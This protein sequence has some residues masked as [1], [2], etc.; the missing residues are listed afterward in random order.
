[1]RF[2]FFILFTTIS[3]NCFSQNFSNLKQNKYAFDDTIFIDSS[4]I[5]PSSIKIFAE[6]EKINDS[7][8]NF[9]FENSYLYFKQNQNYDTIKIKYRSLNYNFRQVALNDS[10]IIVPKAIN[11]YDKNKRKKIDAGKDLKSGEIKSNGF[12]SRSV[13]V[14]NNQDAV[15]SSKM[16]LKLSGKLNDD[17]NV[18]ARA[19]DETMPIQPDGNTAKI[20][21]LNNI[22]LSAYN[23]N[24]KLKAGDFNIIKPKSYFLKYNKQVKG[25]EYVKKN[26]GINEFFTA[27]QLNFGAAISKG[28]Y[29]SQKISGIEGNQGPYRLLGNSGETY[30]V[31]LAGSERVY[32]DGKLLKRGENFDY[33][34]NYNTAEIVFTAKNPITKDSRIIVEFEYSERNYSRF[35]LYSNN[36][37]KTSNNEFYLN[38][39]SETDAKN[40]TIDRE[41]SSE[42]KEIMFNAGDSLNKALYLN[43]DS[44]SYSEDKILYEKID[45]LIDDEVFTIYKHS[46]NP[47]KAIYQVSFAYVGAGKGNYKIAENATNG[48]IYEFIEPQDSKKQGDYAPYLLLVTPKKHQI[49]DFGGKL[50]I[51]PKNKFFFDIALSNKDLNLF[52]P[53]NDNDN[54]ALALKFNYNFYL[55]G[56]D[57]TSDKR[58]IF[59][60][61]EFEGK[62][63]TPVETFRN[64][65]YKRDWNITSQFSS[66]THLFDIG[67]YDKSDKNIFSSSFLLLHHFKEFLGL[68]PQ[69]SGKRVAKSWKLDYNANLMH[70]SDYLNNTNFARSK[71]LFSKKIF[72]LKTGIDYQQETNIWQKIDTDTLLQNSFMFHSLAFFIENAD[73]SEFLFHS[74]YKRR[75]DFSPEIKSLK[76]VSYS[77]N[78]NFNL[79]IKKNKYSANFVLNYRQ[80][81][82][83]DTAAVNYQPENNLN[84]RAL[85]NFSILKDILS[86]STILEFSSGLEQKMQFIFVEVEPT[87]GV[88]TW[89]DYNNDNIKQIDEFEVAAFADEATFVKVPVQSNEYIKVYTKNFT[90]NLFFTPA[91][92]FY[93]TLFAHKLFSKF[94]DNLSVNFNHKSYNFNL[95]DF[96]DT[97]SFNY[98]FGLNNIL[99][100]N[101][102]KWMKINYLWQKNKTKLL[103]F[104]GSDNIIKNKKTLN[105]V[106]IFPANVKLSEKL[107]TKTNKVSSDYSALKNY[108]ILNNETITELSF[109]EKELTFGISYSYSDKRNLSG[110]EIL[111]S[112]KIATNLNLIFSKK[113]GITVNFN[114]IDNNFKGDASTSVAYT[115]LGGLKPGKNYTWDFIFKRKL[116]KILQASISYSG[117]YSKGNKII[118][119]GMISVMAFL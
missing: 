40:Q 110:D 38:F 52:S 58:F 8:W 96:S 98:N 92:F 114:F 67:F 79:D 10:S 86:F 113:S 65:E 102:F 46:K 71:F 35:T 4:Y 76:K 118:H 17:I 13:G 15:I 49:I 33:K 5:F 43:A 20:E 88:Y 25:I 82:I 115:M 84:T 80:L 16:N 11:Y 90:Q 107:S 105:T 7:L 36:N 73:T 116:G 26:T 60:G 81:F 54:K 18:E 109:S 14:G 99:N 112:N 39:Y 32:L 59:T 91:K 31:V 63:F 87:K 12:I 83:S 19:Y 103:H 3:L 47:Q 62:N 30:I 50:N 42:M 1:M 93:D 106:F 111:F 66:A 69:I 70:S 97:S 68:K 94:N 72:S 74:E 104:S 108:K 41:L 24:F 34:M 101:L 100:L 53:L 48:R 119:T 23:E 27:Q 85:F 55:K 22:Y 45:T 61:Y 6:N 29:R 28:K 56:N 77:N 64:Q 89:N 9:S 95:R 78:F 2:L 117:R 57:T 21:E 37:F 44:V 75:Y 51:N